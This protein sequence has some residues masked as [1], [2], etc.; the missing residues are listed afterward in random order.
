MAQVCTATCST[1][2]VQD[3]CIARAVQLLEDPVMRSQTVQ[4]LTR[5]RLVGMFGRGIDGRKHGC[6]DDINVMV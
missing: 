2:E 3:L 6:Y 1:I 5:G 4:R